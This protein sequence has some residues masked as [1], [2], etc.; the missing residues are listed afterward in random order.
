MIQVEVHLSARQRV[1]SLVESV[2]LSLLLPI[3]KGFH[4][5]M[6]ACL[7]SPLVHKPHKY[8][9]GLLNLVSILPIK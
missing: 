5:L 1:L 6:H 4:I 8:I 3:K 7:L 9:K 2:A